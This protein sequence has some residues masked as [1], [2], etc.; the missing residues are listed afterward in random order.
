MPA[1]GTPLAGTVVNT[2]LQLTRHDGV[3]DGAVLVMW[4]VN[5]AVGL[6]ERIGGCSNVSAVLE[7]ERW[8]EGL[9]GRRKWE[10]AARTAG[11]FCAV[12]WVRKLRRKKEYMAW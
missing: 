6:M 7:V 9:L 4:S 5:F 2:T 8:G 3:G 10:R 11:E 1:T 12:S